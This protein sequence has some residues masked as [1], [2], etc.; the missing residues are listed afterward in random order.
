MNF[1]DFLDSKIKNMDLL[2]ISLIKLGS[3]VFG[4]LLAIFIPTL[5]KISPIILLIILILT[6]IR[7]MIRFFK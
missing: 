3:M 2:D 7:P 5:T 6:V 1:F 4:I